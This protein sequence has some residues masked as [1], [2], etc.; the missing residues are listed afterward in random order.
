LAGYKW[1]TVKKVGSWAEW[2]DILDNKVVME[3][4][5]VLRWLIKRMI[6]T[7]IGHKEFRP[8]LHSFRRG[9]KKYDT[10]IFSNAE[11]ARFLQ[12]ISSS[13]NE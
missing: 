6:N 4:R 12:K 7:D 1:N 3:D 9:I 5:R 13:A 11:L 10:V 8:F 2:R